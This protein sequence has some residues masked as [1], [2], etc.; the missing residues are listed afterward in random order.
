MRN[1]HNKEE[2]LTSRI[3]KGCPKHSN[4]NKMKRQRHTQ[5]IKEHEKCPPKP[6]KKGGERE[7]LY[8]KE[9]QIIIVKMIQKLESKLDLQISSLE[10]R[11]EMM[12][13]MFNKDL[14]EIKKSQYIMNKAINEIKNT[15]ERT[16][17]RITETEDRI[18][19]VEDRLVEINETEYKR[20]KN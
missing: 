13:E 1:L 2:P 5:Q 7:D 14:E 18:S 15:L 3:Q 8:D 4:I 9:F 11:I 19:E 16:N 17:S 12:P 6:N 20:K 10:T